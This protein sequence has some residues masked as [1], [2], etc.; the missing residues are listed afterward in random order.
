[1]KTILIIID[2]ILLKDFDPIKVK[3]KEEFDEVILF[4]HPDEAVK[5]I[6]QNLDKYIVVLLDYKFS[7]D[8]DKGT[9]IID[10]IRKISSL[11]PVVIW[12][13]EIGQIDDYPE[14]VNNQAF[15]IHSKVDMDDILISLSKAKLQTQNSILEALEEYISK[16]SESDQDYIKIETLNGK[17]FSLRDLFFEISQ[18]TEIG[19]DIEKILIKKTIKSLLENHE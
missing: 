3:T 8:E 7:D 19:L 18:R 14:L 5:Y 9:Q 1:M 10:R 6:K 2:D 17:S 4:E 15:A 12:T 11:I 13:A 16:F